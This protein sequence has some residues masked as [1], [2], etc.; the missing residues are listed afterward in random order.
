MIDLY[1]DSSKAIDARGVFCGSWAIISQQTDF[2]FE[3]FGIF[4]Y[5]SICSL[6]NRQIWVWLLILLLL[7]DCLSEN[8]SPF[9]LFN[10]ARSDARNIHEII[11]FS[12]EFNSSRSIYF[13]HAVFDS[14][15]MD[16]CQT[17]NI[18]T[19]LILTDT[20]LSAFSFQLYSQLIC[21]RAQSLTRCTRNTS[22]AP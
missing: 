6:S 14:S 15:F 11:A 1:F 10:R 21:S 2:G 16:H 5:I 13:K 18:V 20:L 7:H 9:F 8:S 17:E 12:L 4:E 22:W 19:I 3:T